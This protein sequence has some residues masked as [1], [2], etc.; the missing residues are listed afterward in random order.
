MVE[1]AVKTALKG[2]TSAGN[3]VFAAV[4]PH[5]AARPAIT[6]QVINAEPINSFAGSS[7]LDRVMLQIDAWAST[8]DSAL[9]IAGEI[10]PLMEAA[11]FKGLLD[12]RRTEFEDD[13]KLYRVSSDY[14][15]WEDADA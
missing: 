3:N 5:N 13:T 9:Q 4:L 15:T 7:G 10:R 8:Y 2:N 6:Y 12:S 11:G 14:W 1:A